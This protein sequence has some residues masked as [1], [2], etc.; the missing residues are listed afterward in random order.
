MLFYNHYP[1]LLLFHSHSL[2]PSLPLLSHLST[3]LSPLLLLLT[4]S[5]LYHLP[6]HTTTAMTVSKWD[7][8][9]Q[10]KEMSIVDY[11]EEEEDID[12]MLVMLIPLHFVD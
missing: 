10:K 2:P 8:L 9:N 11:D 3:P 4:F 5:L 12:G 7:S 6:S 1:P